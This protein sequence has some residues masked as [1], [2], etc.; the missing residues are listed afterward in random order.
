MKKVLAV[1][2]MLMI[3]TIGA[4]AS[5]WQ[6]YG[7][8]RVSTFMEKWDN[9]QF[10]S[11]DTTLFKEGLQTNS[12]IGARVK[13][14]DTLTGRFEYSS[15]GKLRILY[16]EW[17][18]GQGSL[19][20]GQAYSPLNINYSNQVW[21][22]DNGLRR[23]AGLYSGRN[24]MI[25]LKFEGFEIAAV[26]PQT[27]YLPNNSTAEVKFPKLEAKYRVIG[28]NWDFQVAGGYNEYTLI[29]GAA[30]YKIDSYFVGVGGSITF[31]GVFLAA[32]AWGGINTGVYMIESLLFAT[33]EISFATGDVN[34]TDCY[35]VTLVAGY[36]LNDSV[37]FEAGYGYSR[38]DRE[39]S[40]IPDAK[41]IS[42]YV[43]SKI[44]LAQ[45]VYVV[46]E[47]GFLDMEHYYGMDL[48]GVVYGGAKWQIDF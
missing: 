42:L 25:R 38:A 32:T 10:S 33:P 22:N 11:D 29:N 20:V 3:S 39:A 23:V 6:F 31:Q 34:D 9:G 19:L 1:L 43:Q 37:T 21:W 24:P 41:L 30:E 45:G 14:S 7:S 2:A 18:F 12:R 16:G 15:T 46:P 17:N 35:G 5:D 36:T 48:G 26:E 28:D 13:A 40:A 27:P 47:I 4:H 44:T 8:A